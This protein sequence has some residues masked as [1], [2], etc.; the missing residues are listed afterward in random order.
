M[1]AIL[2]HPATVRRQAAMLAELRQRRRVLA[3][4]VDAAAVMARCTTAELLGRTRRAPLVRWRAFFMAAAYR[5]GFSSPEVGRAF[6]RDHTTV[7]A[8]V[9]RAEGRG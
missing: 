1:S 9:R 4:F 3:A 6:R 2:P 7:L 5:A 8:A